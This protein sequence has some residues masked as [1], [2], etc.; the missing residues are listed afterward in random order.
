LPEA[1]REAAGVTVAVDLSGKRAG[2]G[3]YVC[4][5]PECVASVIKKKGFERS[6]KTP[7]PAS[8]ADELRMLVT[9]A[10]D[11]VPG[12]EEGAAV[13]EIAAGSPVA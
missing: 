13:S 6:L 3:A 8:V 1:E 10:P 9:P 2:R 11:V 4:Q 5:T 12:N 7:L